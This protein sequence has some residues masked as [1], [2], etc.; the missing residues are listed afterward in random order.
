MAAIA[1][2]GLLH[3][4]YVEVLNGVETLL[5]LATTLGALVAY[6]DGRRTAA[7]FLLSLA[8]LSRGEA[9][10]LAALLLAYDV[11]TTRRLPE[12][13]L[14]VAFA[15]LP[16]AWAIAHWLA[17]QDV[18]PATLGAKTAQGRSGMWPLFADGLWPTFAAN[19]GALV[20]QIVR[21][22]P[23]VAA[24]GLAV[25]V[26]RRDPV[27]IVLGLFA[28][29]HFAAYAGL[30]V[31]Y[32]HWYYGV[33]FLAAWYLVPLA[34]ATGAHL[35][36]AARWRRTEGGLVTVGWAAAAATA[37]LL[38]DLGRRSPYQ[39]VAAP[40]S[41][42]YVRIAA[43]MRPSLAPG[44]RIVVAEVG[45]LGW[46]LPDARIEDTVGLTGLVTPAEVARGQMN[47]WLAR[48]DALPEYV[49]VLDRFA[50]LMF[51]GDSRLAASFGATYEPVLRLPE[52][53]PGFR[54]TLFRRRR[55]APADDGSVDLLS[56]IDA[57]A[58]K[59]PAVRLFTVADGDRIPLALFE[60]PTSTVTLDVPITRRD[61][62]LRFGM[63]PDV[64]DKSD[65]VRFI[66]EVAAD[67]RI[68][69]AFQRDVRP[70]ERPEDRAWQSACIDLGAWAGRTVTLRFRTEPLETP[71]YDFAA[72][73]APVLRDDVPGCRPP[74][75]NP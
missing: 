68:A 14:V 55:E 17:F 29:A 35:A 70:H 44:D 30:H 1:A 27:G 36:A 34:L 40:L 52:G 63:L 65:G 28:L 8:V 45:T 10:L 69:P 61:L 23:W 11:V 2:F 6:V 39:F 59:P 71:T 66:V 50:T 57:G 53:D 74:A 73:L 33:E 58:L 24:V 16:C 21:A 12:P 26:V 15:A 7:A 4:P 54:G 41:Q 43:A 46:E 56:R 22:V 5:V 20:Q 31:A 64:Y 18:L 32:Y 19:R 49:L 48:R 37:L 47:A 9:I 13:R 67:G 42:G 72:W 51:E 25:T 60:H 75:S 62:V 38:A 3:H